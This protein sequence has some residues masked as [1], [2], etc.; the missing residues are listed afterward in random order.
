MLG[1]SMCTFE[2]WGVNLR[3]FDIELQLRCG[4]IPRCHFKLLFLLLLLAKQLFYRLDASRGILG[5]IDWI[6][7]TRDLSLPTSIHHF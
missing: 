4:I 5:C 7:S 2:I 6:F 3:E 1:I